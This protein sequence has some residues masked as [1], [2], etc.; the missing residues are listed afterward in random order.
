MSSPYFEPGLQGPQRV[1]SLFDV[2]AGRYDLLND[3][4]SFGMH[5][6]WKRRMVG[7]ARARAGSRAL[8]LCCGTGDVALALASAGADVVGLDFSEAMLDLAMRRAEHRRRLGSCGAVTYMRG[9]ALDLPF[10]DKS[11]DAVTISYGLRNLESV[12]RGLSEMCRVARPGGRIL[13]L[14][15]GKPR[16]RAW[17]RL[18]MAYLRRIVPLMGWISGGGT[19]AYAYILPSVE[20]YPAQ[21]GVAEVMKKLPLANVGVVNLLGGAM[22]IHL[23]EKVVTW[24]G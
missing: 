15:F 20:R 3:I 1:K 14:D 21:E 9:D 8:D 13:V 17:R 19:E 23:A 6:L 12:E 22:S 18:Y 16:A 11:F 2:V 4:L 5:R 7:L 10:A 24:G